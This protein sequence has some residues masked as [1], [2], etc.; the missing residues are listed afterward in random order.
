MTLILRKSNNANSAIT[1]GQTNIGIRVPNNS[2]AIELLKAFEKVGGKGVVAPSANRYGAVSPTRAKDVE[3]ELGDFLGAQDLILDG[4]S[5]TVGIESTII[6][7][8]NSKP[9]I[10][11]LGVITATMINKIAPLEDVNF[12]NHDQIKFSGNLD[13]H[14]AP[15]TPVFI[16]QQAAEGDGL[17]ALAEIPTPNGSIRLCSP[18]SYEELASQLYVSFRAGDR[19][20]LKKIVV[21]INS[22]SEIALAISDRVKKASKKVN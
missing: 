15:K 17:I 12:E 2:C 3:D 6:E 8:L 7:C 20:N 5:S 13:S 11:R 1:G 4:G 22:E 9:R 18:N 16:N 19:L 21:V 14:Y 10:L